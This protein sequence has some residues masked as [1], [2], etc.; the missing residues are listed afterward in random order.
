MIADAT[1]APSQISYP[2][3]TKL[4]ND[5]REITEEFIDALHDAGEE[6]PRTYRKKRVRI[7]LTVT[8]N[9]N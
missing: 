7:I 5:A 6:K 3:D 1:C 2:Q 8:L 4:L 9:I